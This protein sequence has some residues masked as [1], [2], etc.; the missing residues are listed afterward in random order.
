MTSVQNLILTRL[1]FGF[2]EIMSFEIQRMSSETSHICQSR[3]F[4][5]DSA[6]KGNKWTKERLCGGE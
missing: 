5:L 1:E 3:S 6:I 2:G 4:V